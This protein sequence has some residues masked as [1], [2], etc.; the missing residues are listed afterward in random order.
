M[1]FC[2]TGRVNV[3]GFGQYSGRKGSQNTTT[4]KEYGKKKEREGPLIKTPPCGTARRKR[5][6]NV[7]SLNLGDGQKGSIRLEL[8]RKKGGEVTPDRRPSSGGGT[9]K[10]LSTGEARKG[11]GSVVLC[12]TSGQKRGNRKGG[13]GAAIAIHRKPNL[14]LELYKKRAETVWQKKE[15][16]LYGPLWQG[17]TLNSGR[18]IPMVVV[19]TAKLAGKP[20]KMWNKRSKHR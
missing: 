18:E 17:I 1:V 15:E 8:R 20:I 16:F 6:R 4:R 5:A 14:I 10:G 7:L 13:D 19:H 11:D 2:L 3:T 9:A 12:C